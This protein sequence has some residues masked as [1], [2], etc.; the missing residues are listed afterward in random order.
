L[1]VQLQKI[2]K[3]RIKY[4]I[5][6]KNWVMDSHK[7]HYGLNHYEMHYSPYSIHYGFP[8]ELR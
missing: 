7:F 2:N 8:W 3:R 6:S 1:L 4:I 5:W